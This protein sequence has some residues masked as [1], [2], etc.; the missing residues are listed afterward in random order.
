MHET[1][2]DRNIIGIVHLNINKD[3]S[4]TTRFFI[5]PKYEFLVYG[6]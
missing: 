4:F 2:Q 6:T 1:F 3:K 5:I